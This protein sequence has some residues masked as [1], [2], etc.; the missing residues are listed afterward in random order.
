MAFF[1]NHLYLILAGVSFALFGLVFVVAL[2]PLSMDSKATVAAVFLGFS[3][4]T[5]WAALYHGK[6]RLVHHAKRLG[7]RYLPGRVARP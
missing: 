6:H 2:M 1:R 5:W 7:R 4:V 3:Y